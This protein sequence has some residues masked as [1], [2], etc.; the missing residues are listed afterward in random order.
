M[1][2][3]TF[4]WVQDPGDLTKLRRAVEVFCRG[5]KTHTELCTDLIPRL[6]AARDGRDKFLQAMQREPLRLSYRKLVGTAFTPRG[7]SRCNGIMQAALPGQKRA[8]SLDWPADNFVRWAH[9]LGFIE[10]NADNDDFA[11]TDAGIALSKTTPDSDAEYRLFADGLLSYPP[12]ARVIGLLADAGAIAEGGLTKFDLGKHLGFQGEQGFTTI[13]RDFFVKE[14]LLAESA[15][16]RKKMS[17]NWEGTADKYARMMCGWMMKLKYPWVRRER[18]EFGKSEDGKFVCRLDAFTLTATGFEERKKT[19]GMSSVRRSPKRVPAQ[20]LCTK[21][22][23]RAALRARRARIL[24]MIR[25]RAASIAQIKEMLAAHHAEASEAAIAGDLRGL[26][27]IGL[28][29]DERQGKFRCRDNIMDLV[30]EQTPAP[31][32]PSYAIQAMKEQCAGVL[33][34]IPHN[35]LVLIEMGFDKGKSRMFEIKVAELLIEHCGF[36]GRWLGGQNRPDIIVYDDATGA[37]IDTKSYRRGFSLSTTERDKMLRYLTDAKRQVQAA[38]WWRNFPPE[39]TEFIFL[40]VSGKFTGNFR[41]KL[42]ALGELAGVGGGAITALALLLFS[43]QIAG[44]K[45]SRREFLRRA[46]VLDEMRSPHLHRPQ[47]ASAPDARHDH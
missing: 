14:Y 23:G 36:H 32:E 18:R 47:A 42:R 43:E 21:G 13:S 44:G 11:A 12:A 6:I 16:I 4:G 45:M 46:S 28:A 10:W 8:F 2:E 5:A 25:R 34:F 33:H 39:V 19:T 27:N 3:R 26:E 24:D 15:D 22:A 20:M 35:F 17:Q 40:F 9:A 29:I 38:E 31:D 1:V 30:V 7:K 41:A 37:I